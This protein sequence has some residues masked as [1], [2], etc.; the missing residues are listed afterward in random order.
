MNTP[1][2]PDSEGRYGQPVAVIPQDQMPEDAVKYADAIQ[3]MKDH[4]NVDWT[5]AKG[6]V[7]LKM[8][9]DPQNYSI[10]VCKPIYETD[11]LVVK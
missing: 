9:E 7:V 10:V 8:W 6:M 1:Y 4:P 3:Y 5:Y 11:M 2:K